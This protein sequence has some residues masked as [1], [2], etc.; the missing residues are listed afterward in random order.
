MKSLNKARF[1][2]EPDVIKA[3]V[4]SVAVVH[5][6]KILMMQRR[7]NSRWTLPGGHL[8]DGEDPSE[9]AK[10]ELKEEAGIIANK[11][12]S[13]G[14]EKLTS[15][16]DKKMTIHA[17]IYEPKQKPTFNSKNDPDQEAGVHKWVS[18]KDF[19]Q[20]IK[21]NL[22]SPRNT[23]LKKIG[24]L[25]SLM[26]AGIDMLIKGV[27][28]ESA[29]THKY[30]R[31]Y[32][33]G[34]KWVYVYVEPTG[35]SRNLPEE[36]ITRLKE[37][38]DHGDEKAQKMYD[39]IVEYSPEKIRLLRELHT[40][41]DEQAKG[42]L[43]EMGIDPI[44]EDVAESVLPSDPIR[45][46]LSAE[47]KTKVYNAID[48]AIKD[49]LF[50]R[51]NSHRNEEIGRAF[52]A[53]TN[54]DFAI[55]R[56]KIMEAINKKKTTEE[57]LQEFHR[58]MNVIDAALPASRNSDVTSAG[59][60]GNFAYNDAVSRMETS[61]ILP[62]GYKSIHSR[63]PGSATHEVQGTIEIREAIRVQ[64]DAL[65]GSMAF[66]IVSLM[67]SHARSSDAEKIRTAKQIDDSIK[68][69]FG[70][71]LTKEDWPYDFSES[72]LTVKIT[73]ASATGRAFDLF[74]QVY[75][76]QGNEIMERWRRD[77]SKKNERPHIYNHVM[78]VKPSARGSVQVG[79]LINSG[80]RKLMKS[81]LGGGVIDVTANIDVGGYNWAN[82]GFSFSSQEGLER[83]RFDFR[84]FLSSRGIHLSEEDM[85]NFTEPCHFSMFT[86]GKKYVT[87]TADDDEIKLSEEQLATRSLTGIAGD[88]TLTDS[89]IRNKKS[90]RMALNLGKM[91][92]L[93]KHW[94]GTWDSNKETQA[95]K[96][97][98][99]YYAL[100][101]RAM[102]VF[103]H[104]YSSLMSAVENG[105]RTSAPASAPRPTSA[106][107]PTPTSAPTPTSTSRPSTEVT[108]WISDW[109]PS[110][111]NIRME[112]RRVRKVASLS[113]DQYDY[114]MENA[115]MT[116]AARSRI[117][118]ARIERSS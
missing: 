4:A 23:V 73:K 41:G 64:M 42:S 116:R 24:I 17:F 69:I 13:L 59:G 36:A 49:K 37:L 34:S 67:E 43:K 62:A 88:N 91:F 94:P 46:N 96:F 92:M 80:Q 1:Y 15:F 31:K 38:A 51:L 98:D 105:R 18:I 76:S 107:R 56:R 101:D 16:T 103:S 118:Q 9:G 60:A 106:S 86:D 104:E 12:R 50:D 32:K 58:Q 21:D 70:K 10:R 63:T 2:V 72:N 54:T 102:K 35:A 82:Q 29:A 78:E 66:H 84:S 52:I 85:K 108:R 83:Y 61:G 89:E 95:S 81:V 27:K 114:F 97:G 40:L 5:D 48:G 11:V 45:A 100:R 30:I 55:G 87:G 20:D 99:K 6:D 57:M 25:K 53:A 109:T 26:D 112:T 39:D 110:E 111:G 7:D 33:R 28:G 14:S 117:I 22:H 71:S 115:R 8:D 47:D 79:N 19:P 75:D 74:M 90:G 68:Y 44:I 65:K 93:G 77:F 113:Q 3:D